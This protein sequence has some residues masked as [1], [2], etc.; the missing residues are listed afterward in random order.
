M[1]TN[2]RTTTI[3]NHVGNEMCKSFILIREMMEKSSQHNLSREQLECAEGKKLNQ[4]RKREIGLVQLYDA[5][6]SI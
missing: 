3:I 5:G 1:E 2:K 4:I 6:A